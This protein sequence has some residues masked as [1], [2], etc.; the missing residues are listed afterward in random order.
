MQDAIECRPLWSCARVLLC[1]CHRSIVQTGAGAAGDRPASAAR[2]GARCSTASA[3][4]ASSWQGA[5]TAHLVREPGDEAELVEVVGHGDERRKPR[6]SLPGRALR[7]VLLPA[8][9]SADA[10]F[11][12]NGTR[13][14][15]C[16]VARGAHEQMRLTARRRSSCTAGRVGIVGSVGHSCRGALLKLQTSDCQHVTGQ[17]RTRWSRR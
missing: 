12:P 5:I 1:I 13:C 3:G 11:S 17:R 9:R 16:C 14:W 10:R 2:K 7:Q 6:Q 4:L 8:A 15:S